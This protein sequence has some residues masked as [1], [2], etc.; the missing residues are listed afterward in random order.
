VIR[1]A[2]AEPYFP[3]KVVDLLKVQASNTDVS[4]LEQMIGKSCEKD[5]R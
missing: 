3:K 5:V 2:L 4:S 1:L